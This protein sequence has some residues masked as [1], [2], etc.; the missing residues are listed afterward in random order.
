MKSNPEHQKASKSTKSPSPPAGNA[1][2]K[3]YADLRKTSA[4]TSNLRLR[5]AQAALVV[6]AH[7]FSPFFYPLPYRRWLHPQQ[8]AASKRRRLDLI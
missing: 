6:S 4:A 7:N 8:K 5:A 2:A 1:R 3:T